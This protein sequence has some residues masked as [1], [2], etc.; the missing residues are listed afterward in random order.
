MTASLYGPQNSDG[1]F[2]KNCYTEKKIR[3]MLRFLGF[4][5]N[6][7][8]FYNWKGDRDRMILVRATK[9]A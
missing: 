6:E 4:H 7:L 5:I 9:Q 1:Q 3:A 8:S 2:H